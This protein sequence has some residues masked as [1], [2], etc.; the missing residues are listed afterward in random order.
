MSFSKSKRES[1]L[2][3]NQI[4]RQVESNTHVHLKDTGLQCSKDY[5]MVYFMVPDLKDGR[6]HEEIW[7]LTNNTAFAWKTLSDAFDSKRMGTGNLVK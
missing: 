4:L 3:T 5:S 6:F 2:V 1:D 7:K